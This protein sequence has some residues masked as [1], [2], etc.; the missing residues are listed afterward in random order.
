M[1]NGP[2]VENMRNWNEGVFGDDLFHGVFRKGVADWCRQKSG[3]LG[4]SCH[5]NSLG[6]PGKFE[7][8]V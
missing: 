1:G 8:K 6:F 2:K 4:V 3:K 7:A 5:S